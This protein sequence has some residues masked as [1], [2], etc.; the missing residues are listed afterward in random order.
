M[1][2]YADRVLTENLIGHARLKDAFLETERD[3]VLL[4]RATWFCGVSSLMCGVMI[5][6]HVYELPALTYVWAFILSICS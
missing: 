1:Q 4:R 3:A 6:H 5:L 2:Y